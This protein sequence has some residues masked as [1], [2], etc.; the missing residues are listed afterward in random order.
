LRNP[1]TAKPAKNTPEYSK[2]KGVTEYL[3][4]YGMAVIFIQIILDGNLFT[5]FIVLFFYASG[6]EILFSKANP[7][8][9]IPCQFHFLLKEP[10]C[11]DR[12]IFSRIP[13]ICQ[14][15]P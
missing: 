4:N 11:E 6:D 13:P 8:Y 2:N 9:P 7:N 3:C 15:V 10:K 14:P 5:V 1:L 12:H